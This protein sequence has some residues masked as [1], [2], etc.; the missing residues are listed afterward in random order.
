MYLHNYVCNLIE[1]GGE[2]ESSYPN[3]N[4]KNN[5]TQCGTFCIVPNHSESPIRGHF[6]RIYEKGSC[7]G[8]KSVAIL[9]LTL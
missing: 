6:D 1:G 4:K 2:H 3:N 9:V 8:K 5:N 7:N